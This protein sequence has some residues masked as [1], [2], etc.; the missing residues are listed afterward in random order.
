MKLEFESL[1]ISGQLNKYNHPE[2]RRI[3]CINAEG[4]VRSPWIQKEFVHIVP[5]PLCTLTPCALYEY[6]RNK[7]LTFE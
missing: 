7:I 6:Y 2:E 1:S 3:F 4:A 5:D